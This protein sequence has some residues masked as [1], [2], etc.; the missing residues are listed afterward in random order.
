MD[1]ADGWYHGID[2][3]DIDSAAVEIRDGSAS[4]PAPWPTSAVEDG[5]FADEDAYYSALHDASIAAAQKAVAEHSQAPDEQIKHAIRTLDDLGRIENELTERVTAWMELSNAA[6]SKDPIRAALDT[7]REAIASIV[8][9]ITARR[10]SLE[11]TIERAMHDVAPNLTRI[12]GA[13]LGARLIALAGSLERLAKMPSGTVQVLGAE[14]ALFAHLSDGA[15]PPKHGLIYTHEF[16]HGTRA[17]DRGSASRALAGK[18]AIAA[19]ID[20]Y[21]GE[22]RPELAVELRERIATIQRRAE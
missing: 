7:E 12:A 21:S 1:R 8:S 16:V 22:L 3:T 14:D 11:A 2:P 20:Y 19:R 13:L 17:E 18:L 9:D 6:E 5:T 15:P 10:E 4:R